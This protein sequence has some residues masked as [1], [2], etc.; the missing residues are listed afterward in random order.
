MSVFIRAGAFLLALPV[1]SASNLP[2]IVRTALAALIAALV[3]PGLPPAPPIPDFWSSIGRMISEAL[4]GLSLGFTARLVFGAFE[5]AGQLV[6]SELGLNMSAVLNPIAS[7][8]Q[9]APGTILYLLAAMLLFTLDLHHWLLAGF[10]RSY[11]LVPIGAAQLQEGLL[12]HL[13]RQSSQMFVVALQMT[14]PVLSITFTV[15][16]V[17]AMLGRVVPQ[18]DVFSASFAI[19]IAAGLTVFGMTLPLVAEHMANGLRRMPDDLIRV[20]QW[21]GGP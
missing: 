19:R 4:V 13:V 21:L 17:F 1:L 16:L 9:Q 20:A 8:P 10:A 18:M 2:T 15:T 12:E 6:T 7:V 3:A 5:L 14:A 11:T